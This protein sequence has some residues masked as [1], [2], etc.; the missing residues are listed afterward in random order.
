[1][2]RERLSQLREDAAVD[3]LGLIHLV[4]AGTTSAE[5]LMVQAKFAAS[6]QAAYTLAC[7]TEY[8]RNH[9]D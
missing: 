8:E 2:S 7:W 3:L 1:M 9:R 6:S 5:G 4:S